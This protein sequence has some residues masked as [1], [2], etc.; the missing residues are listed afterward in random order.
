MEGRYLNTNR[1]KCAHSSKLETKRHETNTARDIHNVQNPT[2]HFTSPKTYIKVTLSKTLKKTDEVSMSRE[3]PISTHHKF[4]RTKL[5]LISSP[6]VIYT[7]IKHQKHPSGHA[8]SQ[9]TANTEP[10]QLPQNKS[11]YYRV[12]SRGRKKSLRSPSIVYI[13][14]IL[15]V[16]PYQNST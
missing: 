2:V 8:R 7:H 12:P 1:K 10:P 3:P 16:Q 11:T 4:H 5:L 9:R 14:L 15:A 6:C 13:A